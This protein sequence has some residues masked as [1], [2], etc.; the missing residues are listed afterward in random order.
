MI[1]SGIRGYGDTRWMLITQTIG[2]VM[3]VAV[4]ALFVFVFK[5]GLLGVFLAVILDEAL[6]AIANSIR[7]LRIKF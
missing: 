1:G 5:W 3:V 4:A 2:T 7:F 6:R